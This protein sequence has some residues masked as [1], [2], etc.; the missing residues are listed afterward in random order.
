ME[1]AK[2]YADR[3]IGI[4]DGLVV[5]DGTKADLTTEILSHIYQGKEDQMG[6][7]AGQANNNPAE[8]G[9]LLYA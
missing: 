8:T 5:F 9:E 3:I 2:R 6:D 4:K 7:T 1:Y